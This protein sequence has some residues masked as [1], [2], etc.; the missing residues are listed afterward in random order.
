MAM[1]TVK[2]PK[3]GLIMT[4]GTISEWYKKEGDHVEEGEVLA[5]VE[6]QKITNELQSLVAGTLVEILV[7]AEDTVPCQEPVA[8]IQMDGPSGS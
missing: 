4:E 3:F 7:Q 5:Q 1:V 2:M 8:K 6:T